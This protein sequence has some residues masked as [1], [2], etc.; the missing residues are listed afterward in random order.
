MPSSTD[1]HK[2]YSSVLPIYLLWYIFRFF[3]DYLQEWKELL[4]MRYTYILT[5]IQKC[6]PMERLYQ[7][8]ISPKVYELLLFHIHT[9]SWNC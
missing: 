8:M 7:F 1:V 4:V 9:R 2:G 6:L 3:K 5:V